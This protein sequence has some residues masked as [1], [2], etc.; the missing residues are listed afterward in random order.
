VLTGSPSYV[1]YAS[2]R[3][4]VQYWPEQEG[5]HP[6]PPVKVKPAKPAP[7]TALERR[8][9]ANEKKAAA[10][11]E[12]AAAAAAGPAEPLTTDAAEVR[13]ERGPV[14]VILNTLRIGPA[15]A[16]VNLVHR[17]E[18]HL[19]KIEQHG[20]RTVMLLEQLVDFGKCGEVRATGMT[21]AIRDAIG[22]SSNEPPPVAP[23]A[24]P[25]RER[26]LPAETKLAPAP[27]PTRAASAGVVDRCRSF[28][29]PT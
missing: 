7:P 22:K 19:E 23:V 25:A 28:D 29:G 4:P 9:A 16:R 12:R 13:L 2:F 11:A 10:R 26:P 17:I 20:A 1:R 14:W 3:N 8:N 18:R 5:E 27:A 15:G 24:S 6:P 21:R